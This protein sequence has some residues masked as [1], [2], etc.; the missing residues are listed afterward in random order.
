MRREWNQITLGRWVPWCPIGA[1]DYDEYCNF[2]YWSR[3]S[4]KWQSVKNALE[5]EW[6]RPEEASAIGKRMAKL[7]NSARFRRELE[8]E[9]ERHR[10]AFHEFY[11]R[12]QFVPDI[13]DVTKSRTSAV[14]WY[15]K[16]RKKMEDFFDK[17][18]ID[19]VV[20]G[21][22]FVDVFDVRAML[23]RDNA[24]RWIV[25]F[26]VPLW[27]SRRRFRERA[28]AEWKRLAEY[29]GIQRRHLAN[30]QKIK[31]AAEF[32]RRN[33]WMLRRFRELRRSGKKKI[34]CYAQIAEELSVKMNWGL[35][36]RSVARLVREVYGRRAK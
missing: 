32:R 10:W 31:R 18:R 4:G 22:P 23:K 35:T 17:Y 28:N 7:K 19:G 24:G 26:E 30:E 36:G 14:E 6:L 5:S 16:Q 1:Q 2:L 9:Q 33:T 34:V 15:H 21:N 27:L 8:K 20:Q 25:V 13:R 11:R 29:I 3:F 12:S